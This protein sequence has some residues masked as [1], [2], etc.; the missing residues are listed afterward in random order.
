M[1]LTDSRVS[2]NNHNIP[3]LVEEQEFENQECW[4]Q[5]K[6]DH[7]FNLEEQMRILKHWKANLNIS[8]E[9]FENVEC[10][11][12]AVKL[13]NYLLPEVQL[14]LQKTVKMGATVL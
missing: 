10:I 11:L 12:A 9:V 8:E 7:S 13:L 6:M 5:G 14:F 1:V 2:R 3:S 4:V